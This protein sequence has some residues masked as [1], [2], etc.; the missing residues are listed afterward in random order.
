MEGDL[1]HVNWR[2]IALDMDGTSLINHR[3]VSDENRKWLYKAREAGIEFTFATGRHI[4]GILTDL[5][6]EL[7]IRVPIVTMNGSEV[8][9]PQGE[10]LM[11]H[12]L[13]ADDVAWLHSL[14]KRYGAGFWA[15]A[16]D[17]PYNMD[18][19]PVR[20][21]EHT[22]LK[23]GFFA[24]DGDVIAALWKELDN[25]RFELSNS[26]PLNI[27]VNPL[28]VTK[29]AGLQVVADYIGIDPSQVVAIGDSLNDLPMIRWAGLGIAMG[30]AQ[31]EV[32][33]EADWVTTSCDEHGVAYAVD[34]L[35]RGQL[36]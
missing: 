21:R 7:E 11:R 36:G 18:E 13:S 12:A 4:K 1:R 22:W 28:G 31:P 8:W 10:L 25:G 30:N 3:Y 27:E 33:A 34:Q 17:R 20:F 23:F 14:A 6:R 32:K 2:L 26:D 16:V 9:T 19:F 15:G 35:L 24:H 29:A 5:V